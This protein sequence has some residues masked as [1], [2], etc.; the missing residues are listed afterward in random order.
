[1][2]LKERDF[3]DR[4]TCLDVGPFFDIVTKERDARTKKGNCGT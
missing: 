4:G 3:I 2:A 1:M